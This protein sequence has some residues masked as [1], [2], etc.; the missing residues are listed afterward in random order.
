MR[1]DEV[2]EVG[3]RKV[4]DATVANFGYLEVLVNS[5]GIFLAGNT[6]AITLDDFRCAQAVEIQGPLVGH[7]NTI[8][9]AQPSDG[10]STSDFSSAAGLAGSAE[11]IA[12]CASKGAVRLLTKS[13]TVHFALAG[14]ASRCNSM[15]PNLTRAP[16]WECIFAGAC[17]P[18]RE[19]EGSSKV[20]PLGRLFR[21]ERGRRGGALFR[22]LE[23]R[24]NHGRETGG[25]RG[26]TER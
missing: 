7:L 23:A 14:Y 2:D 10:A 3:W 9:A 22:Q 24:L 26:R 16:L 1:Q 12:H 17:Q 5:D 20:L 6:D 8:R 13:V 19:R 25:R 21:A 11:C 18:L 15:Y 4:A